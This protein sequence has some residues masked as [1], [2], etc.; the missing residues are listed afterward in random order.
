MKKKKRSVTII[1]MIFHFHLS[2]LICFISPSIRYSRIYSTVG[3]FYQIFRDR[4]STRAPTNSCGQLTPPKHCTKKPQ[5]THFFSSTDG[6]FHANK[7]DPVINPSQ[8]LFIKSSQ[9]LLDHRTIGIIRR[10]KETSLTFFFVSFYKIG[11]RYKTY[12]D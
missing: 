9:A 1:A 11:F 5:E 12:A 2:I 7:T 4:H 10:F 3:M 6:R 8:G